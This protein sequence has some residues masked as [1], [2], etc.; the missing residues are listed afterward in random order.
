MCLPFLYY[1]LFSSV[2]VVYKGIKTRYFSYDATKFLT[3]ILNEYSVLVMTL[4][5]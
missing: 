3:A 4:K 5:D 1:I 2:I